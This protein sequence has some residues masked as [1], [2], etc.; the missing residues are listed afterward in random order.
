MLLLTAALAHGT[1]FGISVVSIVPDEPSAIWAVAGGWGVVHTMDG[2]GSWAWLCEEILGVSAVYDVEALAPDQALLATSEGLLRVDD[3]CVTTPVPGLPEG[4]QVAF[5]EATGNGYAISGYAEGVSGLWRCTESACEATS[6][7]GDGLYLKSVQ[8]DDGTWWVTVVEGGTLA[9]WLYRS[10]DGETWTTA[11][12]WPDGSVDPR[13]LLA[14][15]DRLLVWMQSRDET[16]SPHLEVSHD[17]GATFMSSLAVGS[18]TDPVPTLLPLWD[19]RGAYL[20]TENGRTFYSPDR[21]ESFIEITEVAPAIRCADTAGRL[22][23]VGADHFAD[24]FDVAR[25]QFGGPWEAMGC[26][27]EA[28]APGCAAECAPYTESFLAGGEYGGGECHVTLEPA[29]EEG[30]GGGNA[31]LIGMAGLLRKRRSHRSVIR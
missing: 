20:G 13:V 11:A 25:Q 4:T 9:A 29:P 6:I 27:D 23:I 7:Q 31:F 28:V 5:I 1:R 30:Y 12:T 10:G 15:G 21:G 16:T 19:G 14:E 8:V 24:K 26:L 22:A 18:Y 2:G 3:T 17:G